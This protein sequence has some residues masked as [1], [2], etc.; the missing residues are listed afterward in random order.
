M[1]FYYDVRAFD[2]SLQELGGG[3]LVRKTGVRLALKIGGR[4]APKT[5]KRLN[6]GPSKQ[7]GAGMFRL[8]PHPSIL[9]RFSGC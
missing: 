6:V 1:A 7:V 5:G 9:V 4:L 2:V 8:L 3:R